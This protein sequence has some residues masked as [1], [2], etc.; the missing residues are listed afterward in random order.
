MMDNPILLELCIILILFK[1]SINDDLG[2]PSKN[3][4]GTTA[5]ECSCPNAENGIKHPFYIEKAFIS[6]IT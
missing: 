5:E 4:G 2:Y 3:L 6:S 1:I